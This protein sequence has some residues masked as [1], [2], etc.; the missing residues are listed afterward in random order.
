MGVACLEGGSTTWGAVLPGISIGVAS[1]E[2]GSTTWGVALPGIS[3]GVAALEGGNTTRGVAPL[4]VSVGG[5]LKAIGAASTLR[6][7]TVASVIT[8]WTPRTTSSLK[9]SG[10]IGCGRGERG[11]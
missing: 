10:M 2:G 3:M 7:D 11:R 1:L 9:R 8:S 4:G 5:A 6:A